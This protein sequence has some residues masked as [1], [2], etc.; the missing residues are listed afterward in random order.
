[1]PRA[2][3][4]NDVAR[5]AGVSPMTVSNVV[6]G[7]PG[8]SEA[9]RRRVLDQIESTGY[10]MNAAARNLRSGRSGVIG[11]AVPE[12]DRSYYGLLGARITAVAREQGYRV[13]VEETGAAEA[14]E[15][16]AIQLSQSLQYDGLIL[17]SVGMD[18][19]RLASLNSNATQPFPIVLLGERESPAGV[20]HIAMPNHDG[21]RAAVR[22]LA[23]QGAQ[24]IVYVGGHPTE[25]VSIGSLRLSGFEAGLAEAGL[26]PPSE[27]DPASWLIEV[28]ELTMEAGRR[29]GHQ[30]AEAEHR[31]DAVFAITDTV[32]LGVVRGL[33]DRGMSVPEDVLVSGFDDVPE[34]EFLTPS[35]TTVR[36]DHQ[37]TAERAVELLMNRIRPAGLR[38]AET[39]AGPVRQG[40]GAAKYV[41]IAPFDLIRRESTAR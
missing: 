41:E 33:R 21:A 31:P 17:A 27:Q 36:P 23:E 11:L 8:V 30:L 19:N 12:F 10:R 22:H 4:M 13:A 26:G 1:M 9:V 20:D 5:A 37:W 39:T 15:M 34:S 6:N 18:L 24:R 35:L 2:V 32:A 14:G 40:P 7:R 28:K 16:D 25:E 3:T 38:S 29:A